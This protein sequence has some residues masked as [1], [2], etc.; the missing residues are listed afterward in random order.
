MDSPLKW[1]Q[2]GIDGGQHLDSVTISKNENVSICAIDTL[3]R[4][5]QLQNL[6]HIH[7]SKI[8]VGILHKLISNRNDNLSIFI[9]AKY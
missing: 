8:F 9:E 6:Y 2:F 3:F 4:F 5:L 1:N 7:T